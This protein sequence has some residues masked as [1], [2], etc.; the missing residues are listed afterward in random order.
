MRSLNDMK[1]GTRLNLILSVV[2]I[3]IIGAMGLY[4]INSQ[5]SKIISDT[6]TRMFEQVNDLVKFIDVQV[7]K[8][9]K[10]VN[11]ALD[12]ARFSVESKGNIN[13][14]EENKIDFEVVNSKEKQSRREQLN[15]WTINGSQ[16]QYNNK[17]VDKVK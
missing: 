9:Q 5:R 2:F 3:V 12:V 15:Q 17:L 4:T 11:N 1:I 8:N 6:D 13:I 14:N 7:E 16:L 10:N